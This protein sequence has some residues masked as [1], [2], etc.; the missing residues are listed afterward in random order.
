ML[1]RPAGSEARAAA[2]CQQLLAAVRE[3]LVPLPGRAARVLELTALKE[4][5]EAQERELVDW[6]DPRADQ[7]ERASRNPVERSMSVA[8]PT[9]MIRP[10]WYSRG[11]RS[12]GPR[13]R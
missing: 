7:G 13:P 6:A 12:V 3:L 2:L 1:S 8:W 9:G 11:V 5:G 4:Q 10:G